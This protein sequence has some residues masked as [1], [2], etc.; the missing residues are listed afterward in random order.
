[1]ITK[2]QDEII[3]SLP[4]EHDIT[5]RVLPNGIVVLVRP[6]FQ[7]S[8]V[9]IAGYLPAGSIFDSD[10]KLGLADF[11]ASMLMRGTERRT[12]QE[13]FDALETVGA[14]FAFSCGTHTIGF[15]GKALAEDLGLILNILSESV[16]TPV[17]PAEYVERVRGQL[18]T[19]LAIRAQNTNSMASLTFDKIVYAG[20]PYARP[21]DG[22]PETISAIT[23]ADLVD[24]HKRVFGP[25]GMVIAIA[26]AVEAERAVAAVAAALGNWQNPAQPAPPPLP[27]LAALA[28]THREKVTLADKSQASIILG[29]A[30]PPRREEGFMA[31]FLGNNILGQFGLYGRL[32]DVIREEAGLVYYIYSVLDGGIGPGPWYIN[33]GAAPQNV[34]QV[35]DLAGKEIKRFISAPV[36][37]EELADTKT[38]YIGALP[39][40][41]ETNEGVTAA[42]LNIEKHQLGLDYYQRY[43]GLVRAVTADEI[44][45]MSGRYLDPQRLGIAIAG[46]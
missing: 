20:H 23:R 37:E 31:A 24:F 17:F 39:L 12:F 46:P 16:R 22:Y 21:E 19:G 9:N 8:S 2:S 10:E 38:H 6:N 25:A 28:E 32:G 5:H 40:S 35:I 41:L 29:V 15:G 7:N 30:G 18:L 44:Q 33:C 42:L 26:G 13:I 14:S 11:S 1:M 4:G 34:E 36:T 45:A 3:R 27:P 43:A